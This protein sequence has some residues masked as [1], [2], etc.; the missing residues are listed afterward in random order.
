MIY[1]LKNYQ[2]D[3]A[4]ELEEY[5][6][7]GL[8]AKTRKQVVL[9]APTGSGKPFIASSLFEEI[10]EENG[11]FNFCIIWTCPGK[12]ELHKETGRYEP[13]IKVKR[14]FAPLFKQHGIEVQ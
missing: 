10:V 13:T 9:K 11:D 14:K 4:D 2:R 3:A 5:I 1:T 12:G 8:V 7:L 6:N